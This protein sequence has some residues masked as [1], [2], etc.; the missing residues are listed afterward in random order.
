MDSE[1]KK[2]AKSLGNGVEVDDL[3]KTW[4]SDVLRLWVYGSDVKK[5]VRYS[6]EAMKSSGE[7]YFKLRNTLKFLLGNLE[8][9]RSE[10]FE[11]NEHDLLGDKL[12]KQLLLN[13]NQEM[14]NMN[15]RGVYE[16]LMTFVKEYSSSYLNLD[17]KCDLYE[18][19]LT[20]EKRLRRQ[21]VLFSTL[22]DM[23]K[24]LA[25]VT[26]YLAEDAYQ[27]LPDNLKEFESVFYL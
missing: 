17:L 21:E 23:L 26:P 24:V 15:L 18:A 6:D 27:N 19:V 25:Y 7:T 4:N 1:G 10:K 9:Y 16:N 3:M 12:S 14:E 22:K 5:D 20:D 13:S 2:M 11:M 8:G